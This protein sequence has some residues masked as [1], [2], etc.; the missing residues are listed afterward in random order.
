MID[1]EKKLTSEEFVNGCILVHDEGE[2]FCGVINMVKVIDGVAFIISPL[3]V[4]SSKQG[5]VKYNRD[6]VVNLLPLTDSG[7]MMINNGAVYARLSG[8]RQAMFFPFYVDKYCIAGKEVVR[9]DEIRALA[10]LVL[11]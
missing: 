10:N 1:W 11:A 8:N 2:V 3:F 5:W 6:E 4:K 7:L 9:F